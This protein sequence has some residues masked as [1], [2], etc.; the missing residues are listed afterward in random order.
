MLG[1]EMQRNLQSQSL[2]REG[3]ILPSGMV[4]GKSNHSG[5]HILHNDRTLI[6]TL[7]PECSALGLSV[8]HCRLEGRHTSYEDSAKNRTSKTQ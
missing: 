3:Y 4:S 5:L 6:L 2:Q 7:G 8:V 1:F